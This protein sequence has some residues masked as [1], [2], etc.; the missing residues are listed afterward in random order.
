MAPPEHTS[1]KHACY[2]FIDPGRMKGW[3]GLV[4]WPVADSLPMHTVDTTGWVRRPKTGV[5]PTVL[6]NQPN[7]QPT[8]KIDIYACPHPRHWRSYSCKLQLAKEENHRVTAANCTTCWNISYFRS[9]GLS[10]AICDWTACWS[11]VRAHSIDSARC[12]RLLYQSFQWITW[13]GGT[14]KNTYFLW[15]RP[16]SLDTKCPCRS[17]SWAG[18]GVAVCSYMVTVAAE[19]VSSSNSFHRLTTRSEKK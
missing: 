3:V 12:Y 4:G 17:L 6:R 7:I 15:M 16:W 1:D 2:S 18:E 10:S 8:L 11:F 13:C 9:T 14:R 19:T 5:P